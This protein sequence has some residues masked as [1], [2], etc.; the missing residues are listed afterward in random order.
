MKGLTIFIILN[1]SITL[2]FLTLLFL[3]DPLPEGQE[4]VKSFKVD[5][6]TYYISIVNP[7]DL[8]TG[9]NTLQAFVSKK[10][11]PATV[12]Y[13]LASEK[14]V[15]DI[16]PRMPDMGNHTS[17]DNEALELKD[18]GSYE[19]NVNLTMTGLW[20]IHFTVKDLKGNVLAGGDDLKDGFSSLYF[21]VTI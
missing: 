18:N 8:K 9:K 6:E 7:T 21:D 13:L 11:N 20:R 17:P 4:W 14:F 12:P 2:L 15:I 5:N 1:H 3:V 10:N 16:D 19:G